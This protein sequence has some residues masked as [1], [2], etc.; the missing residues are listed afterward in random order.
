MCACVCVRVRVDVCV[1]ACESKCVIERE[2]ANGRIIKERKVERQ[3]DEKTFIKDTT[4]M[5]IK[6]TYVEWRKNTLE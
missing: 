4:K 3:G 6:I 5:K 2:S 1:C